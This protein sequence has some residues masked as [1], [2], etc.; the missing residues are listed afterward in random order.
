M[1]KTRFGSSKAI[2]YNFFPATASDKLCGALVVCS[3]FC[4]FRL[5]SQPWPRR[6]RP[7][8]PTRDQL[9]LPQQWSSPAQDG[10]RRA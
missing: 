6:G 10:H 2:P 4:C 3:H 9:P 5:H 8:R 1:G 7:I